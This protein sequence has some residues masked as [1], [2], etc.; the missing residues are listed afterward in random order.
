M[1]ATSNLATRVDIIYGYRLDLFCKTNQMHIAATA[2]VPLHLIGA[3]IIA[4]V[5]VV[6]TQLVDA[7]PCGPMLAMERRVTKCSVRRLTIQSSEEIIMKDKHL[8]LI[9]LA[10]AVAAFFFTIARYL[11]IGG[12]PTH[13][14][15]Y[16]IFVSLAPALVALFLLK[17]IKLPWTW[18]KTV[19][20]YA[21]LFVLTSIIQLYGRMLPS[22]K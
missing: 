5:L 14:L 10:C 12:N 11:W 16:S 15:G 1:Q 13:R 4:V 2:Y 18:R 8:Y 7:E 22:I 3:G 9:L 20:V 21:L 6:T 19:T 17:I